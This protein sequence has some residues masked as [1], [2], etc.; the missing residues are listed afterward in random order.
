M[1]ISYL[2]NNNLI[3][4]K[5]VAASTFGKGFG[6]AYNSRLDAKTITMGKAEELENKK[7]EEM[8]MVGVV[9]DRRDSEKEPI[10]GWT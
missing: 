9:S 3:V 6:K 1:L 4:Y 7:H 2:G 5:K 8:V 10:N